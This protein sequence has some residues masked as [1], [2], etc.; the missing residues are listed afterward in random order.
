M[1]IKEAIK[2]INSTKMVRAGLGKEEIY[3]YADGVDRS[4][5]FLVMPQKANNWDNVEED[6]EALYSITPKDLARVMDVIQRLLDTPVNER[7]PE[8]KYRLRWID[9]QGHY[10]NYLNLNSNGAWVFVDDEI[11]AEI[12]TESGLEQLKKDNPH[13]A[14]A[15]DAMKE[16]VKGDED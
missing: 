1:K 9:D 8:K 5:Y 3:F 12:F 11:D 10:K 2:I 6:F 4:D 15:I 13:L 16:E 14:P 7:F